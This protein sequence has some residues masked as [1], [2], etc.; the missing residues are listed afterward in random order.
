MQPGGNIPREVLS[1]VLR[2]GTVRLR[3]GPSPEHI[4]I[5]MELPPSLV[6]PGHEY[7]PIGNLCKAF[8]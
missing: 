5:L 7:G 1:T 4:A 8:P 3:A 2:E 6:E